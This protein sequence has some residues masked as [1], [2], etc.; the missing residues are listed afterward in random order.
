MNSKLILSPAI[1]A[2]VL[3]LG[4]GKSLGAPEAPAANA[5]DRPLTFFCN[6]DG[7]LPVTALRVNPDADTATNAEGS[8]QVHALLTW[9]NEHFP[10]T[11]RAAQLCQQAAGRLQT[12]AQQSDPSQFSFTTG[13]V[14]G[15]P[16]ICVEAV[17]GDGCQRDRLL[18]S[19]EA[20]QDAKTV[21]LSMTP[22]ENHPETIPTTRGDFPLS[23]NPWPVSLTSIMDS[24][25]KR[26]R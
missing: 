10:V 6:T 1:A 24:F 14:D 20:G 8:Q 12:Y 5:A 13:E 21:L 9:T 25:L 2:V 18:T 3:A 17:A 26:V 11:E 22:E 16:A 23:I 7:A 4:A 19:L 15:L